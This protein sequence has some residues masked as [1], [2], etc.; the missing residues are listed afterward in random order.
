MSKA[1][2][3]DGTHKG[4]TDAKDRESSASVS[5][6]EKKGKNVLKLP[7]GAFGANAKTTPPPPPPPP[8]QQQ[9][10]QQPAQ[11]SKVKAIRLKAVEKQNKKGKS[12]EEYGCDI[13]DPDKALGLQ[14]VMDAICNKETKKA[15]ELLESDDTIDPNGLVEVEMFND[16]FKWGPLHAAAYY[17]DTKVI[18]TLM[19]RGADIELNDTWYSGTPLSWAAFG[20]QLMDSIESYAVCKILTGL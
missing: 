2:K 11:E 18:H 7:G 8:Q 19:K 9:Q 16:K 1:W 15:I 17:G 10:Q 5:P 13:P 4:T 12:V 6:S 20:G 14:N 3:P